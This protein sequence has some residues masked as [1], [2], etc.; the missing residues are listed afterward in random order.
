MT[1]PTRTLLPIVLLSALTLGCGGEEADEANSAAS[2]VDYQAPGPY[3]VGNRTV[4]LHDAARGRDLRVEIWYPAAQAATAGGEP[5]Q[6]F[7]AAGADRDALAAA[8]AAAPTEIACTNVQTGATR[9]AKPAKG[10]K[11]PTLTF[12]HCHQCARFSSFSLAEHLASHGFAVIAADHTGGTM[13]SKLAGDSE[14]MTG[15]FLNTRAADVGFLLDTV[16][17]AGDALPADLRGRFDPSRVGA[18]G[19]SFGSVTTGM[20]A[21]KDD[22]VL[23]AAGLFAPFESPL[24]PGV[25]LDQITEPVLFFVATEDNSITEFGNN[26][27]R[28]NFTDANA[29]AWKVE[30]IDAGHLSVS[31]LCGMADGFGPGCGDGTRQTKP[32]EAFTYLPVKRAMGIAKTWLGYFFG[33]HVRAEAHAMDWLRAP[34]TDA[35]ALV[36]LRLTAE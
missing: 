29:P 18:Y 24:P 34:P 11:W 13:F 26:L 2:P 16:L 1:S 6:M 10:G 31:D 15:T 22:R 23:A 8:L 17:G 7:A 30:I 25:K 19:H 36:E 21:Q 3:A 4:E 27:I 12:S 14:G 33:A 28:G 32:G 9:D 5:V 20:V 35:D